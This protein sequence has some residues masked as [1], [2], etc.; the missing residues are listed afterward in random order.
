MVPISCRVVDDTLESEKRDNLSHEACLVP[1]NFGTTI[2][3][4]A[5]GGT[6]GG[7]GYARY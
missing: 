4:L 5:G 1:A 3:C 6:I 2:F 7:Q